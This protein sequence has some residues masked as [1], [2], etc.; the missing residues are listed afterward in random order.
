MTPEIREAALKAARRSWM[1]NPSFER[2]VLEGVE[3]ALAVRNTPEPE[4]E[5]KWGETI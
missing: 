1:G 3:A 2:A 5:M 4:P